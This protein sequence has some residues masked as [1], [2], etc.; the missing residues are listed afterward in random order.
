M[1]RQAQHERNWGNLTH[2]H[3][4][5]RQMVRPAPR[6]KQHH[7]D[8]DIIAGPRIAGAKLL[9]RRSHP[10]QAIFVDCGGKIGGILSPFHLDKGD[11]PPAPRDQ[12]NFAAA[13][14]DARCQYP[15]AFEP[16]RPCSERF[17][18]PSARFGLLPRLFHRLPVSSS[19]RA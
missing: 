12:V 9:R 13:H 18:A 16:E 2:C 1:L 8:T 3:P 14:L 5:I 10:A 6:R 19:A 4:H 15:P 7:V 11:S 17:A